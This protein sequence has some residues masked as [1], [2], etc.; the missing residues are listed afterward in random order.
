MTDADRPQFFRVL[1]TLSALGHADE[2]MLACA[3]V[4]HD[5]TPPRVVL[6][7]GTGLEVTERQATAIA[8]ELNHALSK[9]H[10]VPDTTH[11]IDGGR[12]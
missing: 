10:K 9:I 7:L 4:L 11:E 12:L 2:P 5:Q 3:V 1:A 8:H 6:H